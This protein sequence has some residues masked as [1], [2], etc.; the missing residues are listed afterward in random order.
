MKR[1]EV[2]VFV[3][4]TLL[5]AFSTG[6]LVLIFIPLFIA[7]DHSMGLWYEDNLVILTTEL[8]ACV[9]GITWSISQLAYYM[10]RAA[11]RARTQRRNYAKA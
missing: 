3:S 7:S 11:R 4:N 10:R 8:A 5:F 1:H 6:W 9:F 2:G